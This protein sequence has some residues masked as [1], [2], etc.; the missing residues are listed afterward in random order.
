M[1][2]SPRIDTAPQGFKSLLGEG[3]AGSEANIATGKI[4]SFKSLLGEGGAG[5]TEGRPMDQSTGFKS[6]L[7]EGGAGSCC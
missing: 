2:V 3:G 7:G 6:L 1:K 4:V 5:S